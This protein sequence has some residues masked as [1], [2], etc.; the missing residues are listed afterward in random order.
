MVLLSGLRIEE[1]P[2]KVIVKINN[3]VFRT[4]I[5]WNIKISI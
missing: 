3:I 5:M 1:D 2:V 4:G